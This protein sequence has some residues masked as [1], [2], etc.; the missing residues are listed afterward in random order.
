MELE[1]LE[2]EISSSLENLKNEYPAEGLI[3]VF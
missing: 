2:K 3:F 1:D